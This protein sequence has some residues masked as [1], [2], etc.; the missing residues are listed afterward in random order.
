MRIHTYTNTQSL[1]HVHLNTHLCIHKQPHLCIHKQPH[2]C[3]HKH[4][5]PGIHTCTHSSAYETH[6]KPEH[7]H[8]STRLTFLYSVNTLFTTGSFNQGSQELLNKKDDERFR[9]IICYTVTAREANV[10]EKRSLPN[11][12]ERC[13]AVSQC[14][15]CCR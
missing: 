14:F 2:L 11:G 9:G 10:K 3:I 5:H 7:P 15:V 8:M 1:S 6:T 13:I 4:P 12:H